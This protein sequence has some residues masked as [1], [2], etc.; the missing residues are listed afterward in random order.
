MDR[1]AAANH[2]VIYMQVC[3]FA[4]VLTY[5]FRSSETKTGRNMRWQ[6]MKVLVRWILATR[7]T[8]S[9]ILTQN[10]ELMSIQCNALPGEP[11]AKRCSQ[12]Q[13]QSRT[14]CYSLQAGTTYTCV[15]CLFVVVPQWLCQQF[16]IPRTDPIYVFGLAWSVDAF[17]H[18]FTPILLVLANLVD[19]AS[20]HMLV[21]K[22]KPCMCVYIFLHCETANCSLIQLL[23]TWLRYIT[24]ITTVIL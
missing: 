10:D 1:F 16:L 3:F 18:V 15:C 13:V 17:S 24:W 6:K 5:Y 9:R 23:T 12:I 20:S 11:Y 2:Y 14:W 8:G 21:S 7:C 4:V 19:P 22:T